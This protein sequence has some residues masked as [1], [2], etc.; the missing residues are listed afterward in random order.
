LDRPDNRMIAIYSADQA[1]WVSPT[2]DQ[3]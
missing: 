2:T 1:R 3:S